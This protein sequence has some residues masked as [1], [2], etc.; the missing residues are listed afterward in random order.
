MGQGELKADAGRDTILCEYNYLNESYEIGG[1]PAGFGGVSPLSYSWSL[2]PAVYI[3]YPEYP[4]IFSTIEDRISDS[5]LANPVLYGGWYPTENRPKVEFVLTVTDSVGN[6]ATD[7]VLIINQV[8]TTSTLPATFKKTL[9][10]SKEV[11]YLE[12]FS[13]GR[14]PYVVEWL[15]EDYENDTI[16]SNVY[17]AFNF[18]KT[19]VIPEIT[20][21]VCYGAYVT[22]SIGGCR[23][24]VWAYPCFIVDALGVNEELNNQRGAQ[25][26]LE[27]EVV[28][29]KA[30]HKIK[31]I[32]VFNYLGQTIPVSQ[33][34]T[35]AN[36]ARLTINQQ[37]I[38]IIQIIYPSSHSET[39]KIHVS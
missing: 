15:G 31:T 7:T 18:A 27:G 19:I 34:E 4:Q 29:I 2:N 6:T 11:V 1:S 12:P 38:F 30:Q 33:Q 26:A 21:E 20:G 25:W 5:T 22:D 32:Q 10:S 36:E 17:D 39:F 35:N 3:P 14:P 8:L 23:S 28:V 24:Y 9:P 16:D 37:G 13:L